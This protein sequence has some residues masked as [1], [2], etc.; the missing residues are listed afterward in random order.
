MFKYQEVHLQ[1]LYRESWTIFHPDLYE[2]HV[3]GLLACVVPNMILL[4][5]NRIFDASNK[6]TNFWLM[7]KVRFAGGRVASELQL[8]DNLSPIKYLRFK[9]KTFN[10][11]NPFRLDTCFGLRQFWA[12]SGGRPLPG[13]PRTCCLWRTSAPPHWPRTCSGPCWPGTG[14]WG[15]RGERCCDF[16]ENTEFLDE[17]G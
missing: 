4:F 7:Y 12:R 9:K 14:L 2:I 5:C 3:T 11:T 13:G 6:L 10:H 8:I 17:R 15:T 16:A 1:S